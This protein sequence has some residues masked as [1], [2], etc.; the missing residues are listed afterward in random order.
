M[1]DVVQEFDQLISHIRH[2]LDRGDGRNLTAVIALYWSDW[3]RLIGQARPFGTAEAAVALNVPRRSIHTAM[4]RIRQ[5]LDQSAPTATVETD[6]SP[7][8]APSEPSGQSGWIEQSPLFQSGDRADYARG[9]IIRPDQDYGEVRI[10]PETGN[11]D[12]SIT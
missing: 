3:S 4:Y 2:T 11:A 1:K 10:D 12:Y 7:R 9:K 6:S 8:A 5:R